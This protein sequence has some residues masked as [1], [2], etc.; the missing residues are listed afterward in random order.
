MQS[1]DKITIKAKVH[2]YVSTTVFLREIDLAVW[3]SAL[4]RAPS[5]SGLS[6]RAVADVC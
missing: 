6:A 5:A 3:K 4:R 1:A 2:V